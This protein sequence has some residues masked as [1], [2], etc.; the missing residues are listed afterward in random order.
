MPT[1]TAYAVC[2]RCGQELARKTGLTPVVLQAAL[3][4]TLPRCPDCGTAH[5]VMRWFDE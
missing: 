5:V 3:A 1:H 4:T 2:I